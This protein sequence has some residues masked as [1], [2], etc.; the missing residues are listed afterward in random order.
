MG[1]VTD[2]GEARAARVRRL[3]AGAIMHPALRWTAGGQ[4][5]AHRRR[6]QGG[7]WCGAA[8]PL[9]LAGPSVALCPACYGPRA[10]G[11]PAGEG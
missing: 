11:R 7:A 6:E 2:L 5:D 10:A 1:T 4:G 9:T 8:G 3:T